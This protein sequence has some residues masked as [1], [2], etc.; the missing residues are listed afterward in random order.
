MDF[1]L[2]QASVADIPVNNT[3]LPVRS[4]FDMLEKSM[5]RGL[6]I[7]ISLIAVVL[8]VRPF[9]CFASSEKT[10]EAADCCLKGT[11]HPSANSDGCCKNTVPDGN[12]LATA[13]AGDHTP[14]LVAVIAT[15]SASLIS[16]LRFQDLA[17]PVRHPPRIG[18]TAPSLPLLI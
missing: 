3:G 4:T 15:D 14:A 16:P 8:L 18:L 1:K 5:R 9:D 11:C 13:K 12:Q 7:A 10:R 2:T 17:N 6:H